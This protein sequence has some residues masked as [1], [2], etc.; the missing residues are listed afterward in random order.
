MTNKI[1]SFGKVECKLMREEITQALETI[2]EKYGIGFKLGAIRYETNNFGVRL[3]AFI[4]NGYG[5]TLEAIEFKNNCHFYGF[6]PSDLYRVFLGANAE[7]FKITGLNRKARKYPIICEKI[8]TGKSYKNSA[9][10]VKKGLL[11]S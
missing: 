8:S 6:V 5:E 2:T 4:K 11:I 7:K 10:N 9:E 3:N 1:N